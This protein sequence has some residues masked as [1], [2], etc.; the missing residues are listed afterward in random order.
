[1]MLGEILFQSG[2][3]QGFQLLLQCLNFSVLWWE[4]GQ[5]V[6]NAN[7]ASSGHSSRK[8]SDLSWQLAVVSPGLEEVSHPHHK[9]FGGCRL[10]VVPGR[11]PLVWLGSIWHHGSEN[12]SNPNNS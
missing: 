12:S 6:F 10:R 7:E 2:K 4:M 9:E 8:S 5:G 1:M 11:D 3:V